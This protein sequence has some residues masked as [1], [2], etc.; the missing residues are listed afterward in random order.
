MIILI[1]LLISVFTFSSIDFYN[2]NQLNAIYAHAD[3]VKTDHV[4]RNQ[5][6][7]AENFIIYYGKINDTTI[8]KLSTYKLVII[9][10][11]NVTKNQV[12]QLKQ[13]GVK[14]LGYTSVVEQNEN[15]IEFISLRNA[16]F[17]KP[18]GDKM[19]VDQ[20][21]SW[22]MDIRKKGYQN[23]L[24]EQIQL[25][26]INKHLDGVFLDTVGDIDDLDWNEKHKMEMRKTY[27]KFLIKLKKNYKNLEI[28]QNWGF[29]TAQNFSHELIDGLMWEGFTFDLLEKD[30]WAKNKFR[31]I[32][33]MNVD[34]YVV[35][36]IPQKI[37]RK[38]SNK[39][40]YIYIRDGSIYEELNT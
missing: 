4:E 39:K 24:L 11:R 14:V 30:A 6:Y 32:Q 18:N 21:Q 2:A 33:G 1:I 5:G 10:P 23:F 38:L 36:P 7:D 26:V 20:W 40:I 31:E 37:V 9:E 16:W 35:A 3:P 25:H 22:Y 34:F 15:N 13:Q 28:V 19:R 8:E 27:R 29:Y 17:Y 12:I